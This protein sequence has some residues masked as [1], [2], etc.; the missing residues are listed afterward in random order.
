MGLIYIRG[1]SRAAPTFFLFTIL[2]L[3]ILLRETKLQPL[4]ST[5]INPILVFTPRDAVFA[6]S[7]T[8]PTT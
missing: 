3:K 1:K 8:H 4:E 7:H 2:E 6:I 5:N